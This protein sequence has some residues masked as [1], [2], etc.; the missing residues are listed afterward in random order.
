MIQAVCAL[1]RYI[2]HHLPTANSEEATG[3]LSYLIW[4]ARA[5]PLIDF[6]LI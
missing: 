6:L 1:L 2:Q 4:L 5:R 3:Q